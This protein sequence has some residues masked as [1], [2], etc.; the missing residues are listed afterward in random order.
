[1]TIKEVE[2]NYKYFS[3]RHNATDE[4]KANGLGVLKENVSGID[5]ALDDADEIVELAYATAECNDI[6]AFRFLLE[7]GFNINTMNSKYETVFNLEHYNCFPSRPDFV[8]LAYEKGANFSKKNK[9]N[10]NIFFNA[11]QMKSNPEVFKY[12]LSLPIAREQLNESY[13][14]KRTGIMLFHSAVV[15][16][17]TEEA[18]CILDLGFDINTSYTFYDPKPITQ[19]ALHTICKDGSPEMLNFLIENG[20][21]VNSKNSAGWAPVHILIKRNSIETCT[22]LEIL[23]NNG[24]DI[25]LKCYFTELINLVEKYN[26]ITPLFL[27]LHYRAKADMHRELHDGIIGKL[28]E[29]GADVSVCADNGTAIIH[30]ACEAGNIEVLKKC[31]QHGIDVN[32]KNNI[33]ETPLL[34]ACS[35]NRQPDKIVMA[36]IRMGADREI[37]NNNGEKAI[38]ILSKKGNSNLVEFLLEN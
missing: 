25:N 22:M 30:L 13:G 38:D 3:Y 16:N 24:A 11:L 34:R 36:L 17:K 19:N 5:F 31:G 35:K 14:D 10:R 26:G 18:K 33:G 29:L 37:V 21:D 7:N 6:A 27:A 8:K 4:D 9:G 2:K 1:M 28:L 32:L 23:K 20:I 15:N 12:L